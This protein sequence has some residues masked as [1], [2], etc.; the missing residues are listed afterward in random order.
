MWWNEVRKMDK[1]MKPVKSTA[2]NGR[3]SLFVLAI[4]LSGCGGFN[5]AENAEFSS[6]VSHPISVE[7][8]TAS[9]SIEVDR[10]QIAMTPS[11]RNE[12]AAFA[13][14]YRDKG[15]GRMTIATPAGAPNSGAAASLV[16]DIRAAL[17]EAGIAK[18]AITYTAYQAPSNQ[19]NAPV[20]V[21]YTHYIA[22][23][24]PCH[25]LTEDLA[26]LPENNEPANFGCATQANLAALVA[27]PADLLGQREMDA[28]DAD[29]RSTVLD[30]Y[31]KGEMTA[32]KREDQ[33][34][35]AVSKVN[36]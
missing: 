33:D 20:L 14:A 25:G 19:V 26:Y 35:G 23:A 16:S 17:M 18:D 30:K 27:D 24:T 6:L 28:A 13:N 10:G 29:R 36:K 4:A 2:R 32:T 11:D 3:A 1:I 8:K 34:S 12:I 31:R 22:Q 21:S 15:H 7:Q 5:G 9:L